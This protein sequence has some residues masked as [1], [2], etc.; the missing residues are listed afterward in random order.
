MKEKFNKMLQTLAKDIAQLR[1][2]FDAQMR[3]WLDIRE[4]MEKHGIEYMPI[5]PIAPIKVEPPSDWPPKTKEEY[6][7]KLAEGMRNAA[8]IVPEP[9]PVKE[10][11]RLHVSVAGV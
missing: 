9:Q 11:P 1:P 8:I 4:L 7:A 10:R 6:L 3:L 5:L 2:G